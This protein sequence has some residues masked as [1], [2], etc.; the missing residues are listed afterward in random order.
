MAGLPPLHMTHDILED[1]RGLH[2]DVFVGILQR[3]HNVWQQELNFS[4]LNEAQN[5]LFVK[6]SKTTLANMLS[7]LSTNLPFSSW[8]RNR[9][10]S[11]LAGG[12]Y[13]M[14]ES[15]GRAGEQRLPVPCLATPFSN[16]PKGADGLVT[17][18]AWKAPPVP[19][20]PIHSREGARSRHP[21]S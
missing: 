15:R 16:E 2:P 1:Q 12:G 17:F 21:S 8:C 20:S 11:L 6:W 4:C 19:T 18:Q 3:L 10:S 14:W 13:G 7:L 5:F 9:C